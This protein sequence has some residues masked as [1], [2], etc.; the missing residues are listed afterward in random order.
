MN[1]DISAVADDQPTVYLRWTMGETDGGWQYCGWNIDDIQVTAYQYGAACGDANVDGVVDASDIIV[2]V[3]YL[4]LGSLPPNCE[5]VTSCADVNL[6]GLVDIAD[7]IYLINYIF[8]GGPEPCN[9]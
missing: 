4:Y 8:I 3:N 7:I 6:D 1:L 9:P 5:P 2:L